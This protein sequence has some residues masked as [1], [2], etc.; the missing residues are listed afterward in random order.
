V[1][2]VLVGEHEP[3]AVFAHLGKHGG[4]RAFAA[5]YAEGRQR[6]RYGIAN[7]AS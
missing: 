1:A 3:H 2:H 5:Y 6:E 7:F 4:V